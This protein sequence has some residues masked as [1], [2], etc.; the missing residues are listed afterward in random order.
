MKFCSH[1]GKEMFDKAVVWVGCGCPVVSQIND[2]KADNDEIDRG[3]C[4]LAAFV[5]FFWNSLLDNQMQ[6]RA[7]NQELVELQV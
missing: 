4:V 3:L 1:C 2:K 7:K 6:G 5:P